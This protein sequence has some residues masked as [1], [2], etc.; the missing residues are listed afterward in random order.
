MRGRHWAAMPFAATRD[1]C[2]WPQPSARS[3]YATFDVASKRPL[4]RAW[5]TAAGQ[6][7]LPPTRRSKGHVSASCILGDE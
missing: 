7:S 2:L 6:P 5:Q 3:P 1:Q 4:P